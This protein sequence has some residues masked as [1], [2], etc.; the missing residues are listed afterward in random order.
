MDGSVVVALLALTGTVIAA[1]L[2]WRSSRATNAVSQDAN[3][4]EWVKQARDDA[5]QAQQRAEAAEAKAEAAERRADAC[6]DRLRRMEIRMVDLESRE[7]YIA[8]RARY[9][10]AMIHDPLQTIE[11]LREVVPADFRTA[12][13]SWPQAGEE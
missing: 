7:Q 10:V 4:R 12:P 11:R 3:N 5:K 9:I 1:V 13:P 2:T 8:A 6:S